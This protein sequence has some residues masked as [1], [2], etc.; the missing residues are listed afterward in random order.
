MPLRGKIPVSL[1]ELRSDEKFGILTEQ[2]GPCR[3]GIATLKCIPDM[4]ITFPTKTPYYLPVYDN[5]RW[6]FSP[7]M[8]R[9]L[10]RTRFEEWKTKFYTFEGWDPESGWAKR[11]TLES[12]GL[13][14]IADALQSKGKLGK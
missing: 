8:G 2:S 1:A 14:Q 9:V 10:N 7:C 12:M 13:K 3:E 11:S 4:F 5:G 6:S